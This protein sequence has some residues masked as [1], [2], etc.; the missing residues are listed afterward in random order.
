M[1][2]C[3]AGIKAESYEICAYESLIEMAREMK[4]TK[5][6]LLLSQNLKEEQAALK[7]LQALSKKIKPNQMMAE[8]EEEEGTEAQPEI[9][10]RSKSGRGRRAA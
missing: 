6:A 9:S 4:H 8:D 5:V 1:F 2:N 3:G 10:A 7:K